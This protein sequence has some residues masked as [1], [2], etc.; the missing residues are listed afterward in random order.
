MSSLS[1]HRVDPVFL[2]DENRHAGLSGDLLDFGALAVRAWDHHRLVLKIEVGKQPS[3]S[4]STGTLQFVESVR[5]VITIG[6]ETD[7]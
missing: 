1:G 5:S 7:V 4:R 3:P 2:V 6:Y